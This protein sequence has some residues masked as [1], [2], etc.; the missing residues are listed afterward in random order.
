ME[1]KIN[2]AKRKEIK[3]EGQREKNNL[4]FDLCS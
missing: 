2:T 3:T 4:Q 1:K